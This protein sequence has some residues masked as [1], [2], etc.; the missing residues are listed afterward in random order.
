VK[1]LS[2]K[3]KVV[4]TAPT[5]RQAMHPFN[6]VAQFLEENSNPNLPFDMGREVESIVRGTIYS[7]IILKNGTQFVALPMGN[8]EKIRGER[9]DILSI[10]EFFAMEKNLY[11]NHVLPFLQGHKEEGQ[12]TKLILSTSAESQHSFAY[13]V[14]TNRFMKKIVQEDAAVA[15]DPNYKRNYCVLDIKV[16]DVL[17]S[18]YR[19]SMEVLEQQLEGMS[20]EERAQALENKWIGN[21]GQFLPGNILDRMSSKD[22]EIEHTAAPGSTY[23]LSVDV[24]TTINGD[25]FVIHVWKML[26]ERKRMGLVN[27]FWSKGLTADEMALKLHKMNKRFRPEW[28]VMDKGGGGL[29]VAQSLA[30]TVL[31]EADGMRH[32]VALPILEHNDTHYVVGEHKLIL[33]RPKDELVRSAF[34]DD[35]TFGGDHIHSEDVLVHLMYNG[36]KQTLQHE[37][38]PIVIPSGY[39]DNG[40]DEDDSNAVIFD[41]IRESVLQLRHLTLKMQENPDGTKEVVRSR[42]SKVPSYIWKTSVKDG[43]SAFIYGYIAYRLFYQGYEP[44]EIA[45]PRAHPTVPSEMSVFYPGMVEYH[46]G[47]LQKQGV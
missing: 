23:A 25:S 7:K 10:D 43:A 41:R 24:A 29:F 36:L 31:Q 6:Y 27:S 16:E 34:V 33:T 37:D 20:A 39:K 35:R 9:A 42:V 22:I 5:Y 45:S 18:G 32:E 11:Q 40:V 17:A 14:L 30:K 12:V 47:Q 44:T 3:V 4:F 38:I 19:L 2:N 1:G 21:S 15:A 13:T 46:E 28:I 26:P 8:G